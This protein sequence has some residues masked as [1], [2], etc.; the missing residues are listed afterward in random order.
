MTEHTT[1]ENQP[2]KVS[3]TNLILLVSVGVLLFGMGYKFGQY[4]G[5]F[6]RPPLSIGTSNARTTGQNDVDFSLFWEVWNKVEEKYVDEK[7]I[8]AKKM[9]YGAIKGMVASMEDPYTFFLTPDE[10]KKSKDDL[11]GRFEGIGA[12][13]GMKNNLIVIISPLKNSPAMKEG[14]RGGDIIIK[15][16]GA[17]T[18]GWTLNQTVGKIRGEG[19]TIVKLTINRDGKEMEFSIKRET[20]KVDSIELTYDTRNGNQ[21]AIIEINQFGE[22]TNVEWDKA[23]AEVA[24]KYQNGEIKGMILDVRD[25]PGG[26]L[27]SSVYIASEFLAQGK[28]VVKQ[29]STI[30]GEHDYVVTRQGSLL[31]IPMVTMINGGSASA[32]EILSGALRDHK[33]SVLV[34]EKSFG[35]GSVQE[36]LDLS[37]GAGLHV[38]V[39]KWILPNGDWI[40]GKG[41]MPAIQV[42]NEFKEGNTLTRD[43]DLQLNRAIDELGK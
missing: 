30:E 18:Q 1:H 15:V 42:K 6:A 24:K 14:L 21:V 38:T 34:G 20:I 39:A 22:T 16:D 19:G 27:E 40:H 17:S 41:I 13:L 33:R 5:G 10:N 4:R 31:T 37:Q 35:K 43:N 2:K 32:A 3:W 8:D 7:K 29:Q 11:G 23:A 26:Y 12:Q 25:N 36:A 9:Y 28:M